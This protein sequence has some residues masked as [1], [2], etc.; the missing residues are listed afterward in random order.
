MA[1]KP[2]LIRIRKPQIR[3]NTK[4]IRLTKPTVSIGTKSDHI[5]LSAQGPSVT[6]GVPGATVNTRRGCLLSPV[7]LLGRLFKRQP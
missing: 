1:K 4:G 7:T 6:V 5:N 2:S 3:I